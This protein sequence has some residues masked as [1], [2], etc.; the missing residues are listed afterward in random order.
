MLLMLFAPVAIFS[1]AG[2]AS[3]YFCWIFCMLLML[4]VLLVQVGNGGLIGGSLHVAL[5]GCIRFGEDGIK[6]TA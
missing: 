1:S 6:G 4:M 3:C 2:L 5:F